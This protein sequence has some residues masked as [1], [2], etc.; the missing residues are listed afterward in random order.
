MRRARAVLGWY[1]RRHRLALAVAAVM[2]ALTVNAAVQAGVAA[3]LVVLLASVG[4][5]AAVAAEFFITGAAVAHHAK[6]EAAAIEA[7][8]GRVGAAYGRRKELT[9]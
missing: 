7:V 2:T 8:H 4:C 5:A 3:L 9:R 6:K 1:V